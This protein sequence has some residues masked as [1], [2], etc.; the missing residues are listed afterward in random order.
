M[1]TLKV[2]TITGKTTASNVK[3][4]AG[5]VLQTVFAN[6][7]TS[8]T[9]NSTSYIDST[10]TATITPKYS[11]SNILVLSSL[12]FDNASND[13]IGAKL[14]RDSTTIKTEAGWAFSQAVASGGGV[15]YIMGRESHYY[16]DSPATQSATVYKWQVARLT[17]SSNNYINYDSGGDESDSQI[18]LM[19]IAQ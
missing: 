5:T 13:K 2:D 12:T 8:T 17:G 7:S 19:E 9:I 4:P 1:S 6:A 15:A 16:L 3:L 11:T 14:L 18:I 10:L